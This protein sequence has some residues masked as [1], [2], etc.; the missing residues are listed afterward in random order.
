MAQMEIA[1]IVSSVMLPLVLALIMFGMGLG[2]K[3]DD[4]ITAFQRPVIAVATLL[5]QCL[6]LPLLAWCIGI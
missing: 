6:M 3:R 1:Q 4:F 5:M 2:L